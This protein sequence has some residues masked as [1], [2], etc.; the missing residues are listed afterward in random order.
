MSLIGLLVVVIIL[1]LLLYVVQMLPIPQPFKNAAIVIVVLIA[2]IF[3]LG[4]IG[5]VPL[6]DVRIS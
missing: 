3:L 6:G 2:I 1:G 4:L 5:V